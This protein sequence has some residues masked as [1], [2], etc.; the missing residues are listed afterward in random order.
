MIAQSLM[1]PSSHIIYYNLTED[2]RTKK[3]DFSICEFCP[4]SFGL[5]LSTLTNRTNI[6]KKHLNWFL[7]YLLKN[8]ETFVN[9]PFPLYR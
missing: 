7:N 3:Y 5:T 1:D 6:T 8:R 9:I 4:A 2:T